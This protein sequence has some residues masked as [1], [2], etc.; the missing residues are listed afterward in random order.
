MEADNDG[1]T[2]ADSVRY[3]DCEWGELLEG[4]KEQLQAMGLGVGLAFPGELGGPRAEL[5]TRDPRG[6]PVTISNRY[7]DDDRF[8]AYVTFPNWP[9]QPSLTRAW[10]EAAPGV[11]RCAD[12]W[13]D[14]YVGCARSLSAAGLICDDQLP[15]RPGMRKQRVTIL[16]DGT[17]PS[18]APTANHREARS[19]GARVVER[20]SANR[21]RVRI[22]LTSEERER[23]RSAAELAW[24]EWSLQVRSRR[25]P[26]RLTPMPSDAVASLAAAQSRAARDIRFQ[27]MLA[28]LVASADRGAR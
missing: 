13:F 19:P 6:F 24:A 28:R 16:P 3:T 20:I 4:R 8:T 22:M 18:G 23:R 26:S 17:I 21:F 2:W 15:G 25:R 27:G 14:E 11:Q 10:V 9:T 7:R 1:T 12:T 5:K